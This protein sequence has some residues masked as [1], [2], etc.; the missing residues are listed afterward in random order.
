MD[1]ERILKENHE[2][3]LGFRKGL[4]TVDV[5]KRR[6]DRCGNMMTLVF[7]RIKNPHM[8]PAGV[9]VLDAVSALLLYNSYGIS[10]D[11]ILLICH[12]HGVDCDMEGLAKLIDEQQSERTIKA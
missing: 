8:F 6:I 12:S 7:E 4:S 1:Y 10:P 9:N 2:R 5:M 3:R 11:I